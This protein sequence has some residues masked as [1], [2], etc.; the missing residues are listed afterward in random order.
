M[1][2]AESSAGKVEEEVKTVHEEIIKITGGRT[3]AAQKKLNEVIKKADK[4][5]SEIAKLGVAIKTAERYVFLNWDFPFSG[6]K[7]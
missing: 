3:N 2:K 1:E 6:N 4:V 7:F 5:S